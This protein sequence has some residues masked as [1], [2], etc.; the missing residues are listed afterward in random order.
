MS[1]VYFVTGTDTDVGK[2]YV[3]NV[4]M[5]TLQ[6]RGQSVVGLKPVAAGAV[7]NKNQWQNDDALKLMDASSISLDYEQINPF[8]F[9]QAIAPHIAAELN[10]TQVTLEQV[11]QH[12]IKVVNDY[13]KVDTFFVEGAGGWLVPLNKEESFSDIPKAV[14][15]KVI[16]VVGMKLGC[17]NHALL[18][19]QSIIN[20][21]AELVGW[22][23]NQ[24]QPNM[25][26]Y[27]QNLATLELQ[28]PCPLIAEV[29]H[30][31]QV[32]PELNL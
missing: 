7:L 12:L 25:D 15:S 16:L 3:C 17:I 10:H 20:Q 1:D 27:Q 31:S 30:N 8:C 14:N 22:I 9:P 32:L 4:L 18:T 28:M 24:V 11:R 26:V 29:T 6:Q 21:G 19:A 2:T 5:Q 13:S 23:A